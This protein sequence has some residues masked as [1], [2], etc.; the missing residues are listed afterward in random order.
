MA[1]LN[2][3]QQWILSGIILI[4]TVIR[5]KIIFPKSNPRPIL[6]D[7]ALWKSDKESFIKFK[8][9][10]YDKTFWL[11]V[12]ENS[13]SVFIFGLAVTLKDWII[14][15]IGFYPWLLILLGS[16]YILVRFALKV[17]PKAMNQSIDNMKTLYEM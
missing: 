6:Q 7:L 14:G 15:I 10:Q 13:F 1:L 11:V 4:W 5:V 16:T 12:F 9:Y 17:V 3:T 8:Q 2:T